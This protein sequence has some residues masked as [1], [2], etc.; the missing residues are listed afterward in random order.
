[1]ARAPFPIVTLIKRE[2]LT[3]LRSW[4]SFALLLGLLALLFYA[5]GETMDASVLNTTASGAMRQFFGIL[6]GCL[7][8]VAM[9]IV[10]VMAAVSVNSERESGNWDLLATSLIPPS[11]IILGKYIAVL[12]YYL[13]FCVAVTP[14]AGLVYF[15]AGV[16]VY[17]FFDAIL[18]ILPAALCNAALGIW[19]SGAFQ[20]P[21]RAVIW[22]FGL[23]VG[24][25]ALFAGAALLVQYSRLFRGGAALF[26]AWSPLPAAPVRPFV[27][28]AFYQLAAGLFFLLLALWGARGKSS[29]LGAAYR[30]AHDAIQV[31]RERLFAPPPITIPDRANPFGYKDYYGSLLRRKVAAVAVF[32]FVVMVYFGLLGLFV[33][34]FPGAEVSFGIFERLLLLGLVPPLVAIMVV[35][36]REATTMDMHRMT[37]LS[38][39]SL[40]AGKILG[41]I[42]LTR[43]VW[44]AI[45][46]CK[47]AVLFLFAS[48]G[49]ENEFGLPAYIFWLDLLSLPLHF[50]LVIFTALMG[51][52]FPRSLIAAIGS[53]AGCVFA[54]TLLFAYLQLQMLVGPRSGDPDNM[55]AGLVASH[56]MLCAIALF[57]TFVIAVVRMAVLW[58]AR[59]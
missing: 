18:W 10:P 12:V 15:Y 43:P 20:R 42:R 37:L 26:Y 8:T 48:R 2:L 41:V 6:I 22:T 50:V 46:C 56:L 14:F 53:A 5:A 38:S 32:L 11:R 54:G 39:T 23:I 58:E 45:L 44:L 31:T 40:L 34:E 13:L 36:E 24:M 35:R 30:G 49:W 29:R 55:V 16:D 52:V 3:S 9:A 47:I 1:M 51:A 21:A 33:R 28:Y 25:G 7:Y 17:Q 59:E 57:L 27:L 4:R 19:A